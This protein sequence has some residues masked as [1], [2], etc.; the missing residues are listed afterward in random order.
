MLNNIMVIRFMV[1]TV[2]R[3]RQKMQIAC[4]LMLKKLM[5]FL[6]L[7][8]LPWKNYGLMARYS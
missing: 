7:K 4:L 8:L 6:A 1:K 2:L 3:W 5:T